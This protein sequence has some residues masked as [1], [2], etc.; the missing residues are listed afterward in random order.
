[1]TPSQYRVRDHSD[2]EVLP[3]C[4]SMFVTRPQRTPV[5]V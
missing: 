2:L 4:M 1:V 5:T 3:S